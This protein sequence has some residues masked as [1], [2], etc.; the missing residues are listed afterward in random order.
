[1][2]ILNDIFNLKDKIKSDL[3]IMRNCLAVEQKRLDNLKVSVVKAQQYEQAAKI[4]D[5]E[6]KLTALLKEVEN[7]LL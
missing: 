2:S 1:M 7:N 3:E 4:H 5:I 6:N